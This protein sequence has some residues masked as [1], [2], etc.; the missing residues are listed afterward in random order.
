[1]SLPS[2][3]IHEQVS[4]QHQKTS[5]RG[6]GGGTSRQPTQHG[7]ITIRRDA[8]LRTPMAEELIYYALPAEGCAMA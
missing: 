2:K 3:I 7:A 5:T 8:R 1:M 4:H 6:G